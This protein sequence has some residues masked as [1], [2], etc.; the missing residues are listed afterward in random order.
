MRLGAKANKVDAKSKESRQ[1]Q[2]WKLMLSLDSM[3]SIPATS[4]DKLGGEEG[5]EQEERLKLW[6]AQVSE[7]TQLLNSTLTE[8]EALKLKNEEITSTLEVSEI[9]SLINFE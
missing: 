9:L 1:E 2:M 8:L 3:A 5:E 7:M 4:I 6:K